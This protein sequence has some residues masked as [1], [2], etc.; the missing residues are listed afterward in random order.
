MRTGVRGALAANHLAALRGQMLLVLLALASVTTLALIDLRLLLVPI[1]ITA[2]WAGEVWGRVARAKRREAVR[3]Q[4]ESQRETQR[5][6]YHDQRREAQRRQQEAE[7]QRRA[8][9]ER[10]A[11]RRRRQAEQE[12]EAERR[13][14]QAD[15]E[16]QADRQRREAEQAREADRRRQRE[17]A[18]TARP[19]E[20][21]DGWWTV[22]G[23]SADA[24]KEEIVRT[25]RCKMQQYHPDRVVGLAPE[26]VELAESRTKALNA[27]YAE[28][29]R[30]RG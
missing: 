28:A 10:E 23:V 26:I 15:Q 30:A 29:R 16:R 4:V 12:R 7:R 17:R 1:L 2:L 25:Y 20:K 6:S 14:Q 5:R 24:S 3:R 8:E 19:A 18:R 9:Q 27:A 22:L 21:T 13:R 11:E